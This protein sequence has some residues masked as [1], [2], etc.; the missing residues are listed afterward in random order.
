MKRQGTDMPLNDYEADGCSI[1]GIDTPAVLSTCS[2]GQAQGILP[3]AFSRWLSGVVQSA[4]AQS[5]ASVLFKGLAP[6]SNPLQ[7]YLRADSLSC[8]VPA[9][10]NRV[11]VPAT[12]LRVDITPELIT[13]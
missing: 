12:L 10:R 6:S 8:V 13:E 1:N 5:V 11:S 9:G 4:Q 7:L 3:T 2:A